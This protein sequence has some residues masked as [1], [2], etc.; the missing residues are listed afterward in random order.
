MKIPIIIITENHSAL[1][2]NTRAL[3]TEGDAQINAGP[4]GVRLTTVTAASI[5]RD[6]QDLLQGTLSFKR[7]LLWLP[8]RVQA[9]C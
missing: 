1:P 8:T 6:G 9:P 4:A 2:V 7:P 3:Y 5:A